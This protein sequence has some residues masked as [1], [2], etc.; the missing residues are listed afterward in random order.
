MEEI[1]Y[2]TPQSGE[3]YKSNGDFLGLKFQ[4]KDY[5]RVSLHRA[6]PFSKE[7]SFISVRDKENNEIG[8]IKNLSDFSE[9]IERLFNVELT[10]RYLL[11]T[12]CNIN[13][14]KEEFGYSYWDVVTNIGPKKF[15][16]KKDNSSFINIKDNKILITD[17]DGNRYE[18]DDY[19]K[20]DAR[21]Y[22]LI[23]LLL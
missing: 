15:T 6:F 8:L 17:V 21:S 22:K 11:P 4:D 7:D 23:E 5:S 16:I 9:D 20:L 19:T 18:I 13:S 12:V 1:L 10:R 3:F 14:V 2:I